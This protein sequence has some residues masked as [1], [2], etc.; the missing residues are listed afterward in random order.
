MGSATRIL[1]PK[2]T[3]GKDGTLWYYRSLVDAFAG[4]LP[5]RLADEL[6]RVVTDLERLS[7]G[8]LS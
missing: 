2:F 5:K 1:L 7:T 8:S 4:K 6:E 3:G